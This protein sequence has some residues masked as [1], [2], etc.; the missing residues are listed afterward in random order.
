MD[1]A[2]FIQMMR[3]KFQD[4]NARMA[5]LGLMLDEIRLKKMT[6]KQHMLTYEEAMEQLSEELKDMYDIKQN[7]L[8]A[9]EMKQFMKDIGL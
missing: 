6:E 7:N 2:Q 9:G 3:A 4:P 8:I 5:L 1:E